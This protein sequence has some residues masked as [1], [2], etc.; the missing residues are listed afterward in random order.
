MVVCVLLLRGNGAWARREAACGEHE[1]GEVAKEGWVELIRRP[2]VEDEVLQAF[3]GCRGEGRESP[4]VE[5]A[6]T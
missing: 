1:G 5:Q 6:E 2:G 4:G 3:F